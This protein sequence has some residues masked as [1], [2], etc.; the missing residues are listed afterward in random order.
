MH[1]AL[2]VVVR[3]IVV[4]LVA[5]MLNV[6]ASVLAC[7]CMGLDEGDVVFTGTVV[8]S[9]NELAPLHDIWLPAAGVYTFDVESVERGESFDGRVSSGGATCE[10]AYQVGATYRVHAHHAPMD[11]QQSAA[12]LAMGSCTVRPELVAP[13]AFFTALPY[14]A[15]SSN[16]LPWLGGGLLL[17]VLAGAYRYSRR[18]G[19][20]DA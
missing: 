19:R 16:G 14:W 15:L 3:A 4:A 1:E 8:D 12:T 20:L 6:P 5:L 13:A 17:A 7:Q 9:P 11:R 18:N 2:P 10:S